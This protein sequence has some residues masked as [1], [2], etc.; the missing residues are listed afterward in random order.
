MLIYFIN[1][2][3][4]RALSEV[5]SILFPIIAMIGAP[6]EREPLCYESSEGKKQ[7]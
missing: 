4:N 6:K 5:K 2:R 3:A 1:Y 7:I